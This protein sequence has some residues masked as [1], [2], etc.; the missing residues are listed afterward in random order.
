MIKQLFASSLTLQYILDG[1]K[2]KHGFWKMVFSMSCGSFLKKEN[3]FFPNDNTCTDF[4]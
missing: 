2:E 1:V 3:T 4:S